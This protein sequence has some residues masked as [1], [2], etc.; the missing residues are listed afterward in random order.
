MLSGRSEF[1]LSGLSNPVSYEVIERVD[2][3]LRY[4]TWWEVSR[5]PNELVFEGDGRRVRYVRDG[6][7]LTI[8]AERP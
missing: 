8:Y 6:N 7:V 5:G 3:R 4:G 2:G 1:G